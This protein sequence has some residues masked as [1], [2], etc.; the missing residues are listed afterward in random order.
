MA[1][2]TQKVENSSTTR[3]LTIIPQVLFG[4][5]MIDRRPTSAS[6]IVVLLKPLKQYC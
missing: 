6:G 5:E 4:Y 2:K 1:I 3:Y